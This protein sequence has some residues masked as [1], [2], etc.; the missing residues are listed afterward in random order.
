MYRVTVPIV[1][2]TGQTITK[3]LLLTEG[4]STFWRWC[5]NLWDITSLGSVQVV[6]LC[7]YT[8]PQLVCIG[9]SGK[10]TP[11]IFCSNFVLRVRVIVIITGIVSYLNENFV[12]FLTFVAQSVECRECYGRVYSARIPQLDTSQASK[13]SQ[14][15]IHNPFWQVT[16]VNCVEFA[17]IHR[18]V[19][20]VLQLG[21][22]QF[23]QER[24]SD[25][26]TLPDNTGL[27]FSTQ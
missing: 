27:T 15:S 12:V 6:G 7:L 22:M 11:P 24:S 10:C 1:F 25:Q 9:F 21:N 3:R 5:N 14:N 4:H 17:A 16:C 20:G 23:K 18:T 26:A 13:E 8:I 2:S 19:S